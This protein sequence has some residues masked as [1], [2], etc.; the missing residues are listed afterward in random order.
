MSGFFHNPACSERL[1]PPPDRPRL[2]ST[3]DCW[4]AP[5]QPAH[6]RFESETWEKMRQP[7]HERLIPNLQKK[8]WAGALSFKDME[9]GMVSQKHTLSVLAWT[10]SNGFAALAK[11]LGQGQAQAHVFRVCSLLCPSS[12]TSRRNVTS[13]PD[14]RP[15]CCFGW[16][17]PSGHP[18]SGC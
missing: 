16:K 4:S 5:R 12:K 14:S 9:V 11:H 1:W 2:L 17:Q 7:E 8:T 13:R 15:G 10:P 6:P 3:R 18:N